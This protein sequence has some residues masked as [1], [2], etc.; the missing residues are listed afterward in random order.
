MG[1]SG[2]KIAIAG[3]NVRSQYPYDFDFWSK[4]QS[5][6]FLFKATLSQ[7][8]SSGACSG[9]VTYTHNLGFKPL[10]LSRANS[11]VDGNIYLLP[12]TNL[13]DGN[14][15]LCTSDNFVESLSYKIKDNTI[16]ITYDASCYIP[17]VSQR[18]IDV[19]R[20]YN[21]ELFFYMF[22]LGTTI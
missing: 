14:K 3:K 18:C 7:A 16:D 20:T 17:Q 22:E 1:D 4:F 15:T 11:I 5:L 9:I 8:V 12:F 6:P 19:S 2:H 13:S 21:I 10:V